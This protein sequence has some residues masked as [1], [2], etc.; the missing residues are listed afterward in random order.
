M[1]DWKTNLSF[2]DRL[3]ETA[4]MQVSI[5][6][7]AYKSVNP[8]C[9][10]SEATKHAKSA[11]ENAR[12]SALTLQEYHEVCAKEVDFLLKSL[13]T[14]NLEDRHVHKHVAPNLP[15]HGAQIGRYINAQH[16][17]DG[18]FS[19]VFKAIDPD[20]DE[21]P[22]NP[23][24]T[25]LVALKITT[26]EM[27]QPPHDSRREARILTSAAKSAHIIP[28]LHTFEQAGGHFVLVFPFLPL[29]LTDLLTTHPNPPLPH[30][31]TKPL[32]R[33]L[34]SGLAHLHR[35]GIIHRDIKPSNL[36]LA[37]AQG[38]VYLSDF[39]IAWSATDPGSEPPES[40]IL[41]V[42]TTC[43]RPPE[44]LFGHRGYGT[45]LDLW[46]AG[47]VAAQVVALGRETLFDAGDLGSELAL[48]RS[49]FE[50]LGTQTDEEG[51]WPEAREFPDWGKMDFTRYPGK[52]WREILPE[53]EPDARDLVSRL[54][55]F[56]SGR[57]LR[58]DE[59]LKHPY[60]N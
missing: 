11:E 26:A 7:K 31:T 9:A 3:A 29:S 46:A 25:K 58:A 2:S 35:N 6:S 59:A 22:N 45:A 54:V 13:P 23:T 1:A 30:S 15:T 55:V 57:R 40:K 18:L 8:E 4:K 47:C 28:L 36:L 48:I 44:L 21:A 32:L 41:D 12:K 17:N 24:P 10:S 5:L 39:G 19:E 49:V 60:L 56:E 53:A 43:Y 33:D 50:T 14:G 20:A 27:M 38:P 51:V 16:H 34:F 37:S 42:G 52:S